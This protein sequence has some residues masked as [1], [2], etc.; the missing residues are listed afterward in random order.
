MVTAITGS[1]PIL[2][3]HV[4]TPLPSVLAQPPPQN[5]PPGEAG[6]HAAAGVCGRGQE[7]PEAPHA[8]HAARQRHQRLPGL[9]MQQARRGR[10]REPGGTNPSYIYSGSQSCRR[11][12][13]RPSPSIRVP[14]SPR[15]GGLPAAGGYMAPGLGDSPGRAHR[16][17]RT[18]RRAARRR[19]Q[20]QA[21]AGPSRALPQCTTAA[22]RR[23][24]TSPLTPWAPR[25]PGAS[26]HAPPPAPP[27]GA[28]PR[29]VRLP[30]HPQA[31]GTLAE[32]PI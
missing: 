3:P 27:P 23:R 1:Q 25:E 14:S 21:L 26:G 2:M 7:F 12:A 18:A 5:D 29:T 28:R 24:C 31:P 20:R 6:A 32:L 4:G 8:P 13:R 11:S 19:R 30:P 10:R 22:R 16:P 9:S 15:R 17:A